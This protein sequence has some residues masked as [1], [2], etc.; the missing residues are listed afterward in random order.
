MSIYAFDS[1]QRN[2]YIRQPTPYYSSKYFC[3]TEYAV[4]L[5]NIKNNT[6]YK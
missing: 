4:S 3:S 1:Q 6:L 5:R 2:L